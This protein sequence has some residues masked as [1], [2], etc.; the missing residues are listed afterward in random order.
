MMTS[1]QRKRVLSALTETCRLLGR[2]G[3]YLP[4][5]R[6]QDRIDFYTAHIAKLEAM[7]AAK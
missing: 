2:E 5:N 1:E 4:E 6:K 3:G 7:L